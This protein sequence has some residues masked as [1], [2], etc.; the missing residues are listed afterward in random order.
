[1]RRRC[2]VSTSPTRPSYLA[3]Y[4]GDD[5]ACLAFAAWC[6]LPDNPTD[7]PE[8]RPNADGSWT[9]SNGM[10]TITVRIMSEGA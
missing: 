5:E 2:L 9:V 3:Y 7:G 4:E 6:A 10:R 8:V 1:M